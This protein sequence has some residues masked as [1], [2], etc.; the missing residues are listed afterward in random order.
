MDSDPLNPADLESF[1]SAARIR[2]SSSY[3][4]GTVALPKFNK[5]ECS[6]RHKSKGLIDCDSHPS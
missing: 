1:L 3:F 4:D 5:S 6:S 2:N